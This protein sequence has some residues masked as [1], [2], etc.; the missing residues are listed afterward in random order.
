M[1]KSTISMAMFNSY[2]SL[3]RGYPIF[4]QT[5][6]FSNCCG[7]KNNPHNVKA[8]RTP[9]EGF[10][11]RAWRRRSPNH[12]TTLVSFLQAAIYDIIIHNSYTNRHVYIYISHIY[13]H[14]HIPYIIYTYTM[15]HIYIYYTPYIYIYIIYIYITYLRYFC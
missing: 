6:A 9:T 14:I 15:Y 8:Q 7:R 4:R 10:F 13:I 12:A 5:H 3:P 11:N 1:G 2:V